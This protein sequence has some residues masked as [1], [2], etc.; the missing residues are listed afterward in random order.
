MARAQTASFAPLRADGNG[1]TALQRRVSLELERA[2]VA[3]A[4]RTVMRAADLDLVF[5]TDLPGLEQRISIDVK[6]VTAAAALLRVLENTRLRWLVS[7]AGQAVLVTADDP[8]AAAGGGVR[9]V[10]REAGGTGIAHVDI[11]AGGRTALTDAGG[12]FQLR[13]LSAGQHEL[14]A[15]RLGYRDTVLHVRVADGTDADITID[16]TSAP[17]PLA[18]VVVTPGYFGML[19][20]SVS[21]KQSLSREDIETRPQLGDD[22][23]RAV[24]RLPG[25]SAHDL[26]AAFHV[27]GGAQREVLVRLDGLELVEPFHLK[28]FEGGVSIIDVGSIGGVDLITGGFSAEY[29]NRLTGV[30]DMRTQA[31]LPG[32]GRTSLG[33]S[34]TNLRAAS[35]GAFAGDRGR[36]LFAAR[37]GYLDLALE[38]GNGNTALSPAYYDVLGK[39]EYEIAPRTLLSVHVLHAGDRM[40]YDDADPSEAT[41]ESKYGSSYAWLNLEARPHDRVSVLSVAVVG[42]LDWERLGVRVRDPRRFGG[43]RVEDRRSY[44]FVG[45]RQ[46]WSIEMS[47]RVLLKAGFD[48]RRGSAEYDYFSWTED[49]HAENGSVVATFDTTLAK[50]SPEGTSLGAYVS[51]RMRLGP[52]L[53]V[54]VGGEWSRHSHTGDSNVNPRANF[55]LTLAGNTLRGAWGRYSQAQGLH[56]LQAQDGVTAFAPAERAEQRVLSIERPL[57]NGLDVRVEAYERRSDRLRPRFL[58]VDNV[59]DMLP[60]V[61]RSRRRI[62]AERGRARG[63]EFIGRRSGSRFD[64]TASYALAS[65]QERVAGEWRPAQR[66]QR[67]ALAFDLAWTPDPRWRLAG[68]WQYHSGWAR[69]PEILHTDSLNNGSYWFSWDYGDYNTARLPAYHRMDLRV[70]RLFETRRGRVSVFIDIWNVYNRQ[71][72]RTLFTNV[73]GVRD[74]QPVTSQVADAMI[75]R[76]P[77]FGVFWEF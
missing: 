2:T 58:N 52:P 40:S 54:E 10:V 61:T 53:V 69:T 63:I 73:M 42:G 43:L 24:H 3:E 65:V 14:R 70:S 74:G 17:T 72:V 12:H 29:G 31:V 62:D 57:G 13:N 67:H 16:M 36:W 51:Q 26:S 1:V 39:V 20:Q 68:A 77:S 21:T 38:L 32:R 49:W 23:F 50:A 5:R 19:E 9:G 60:E 55:A 71:N 41:L 25:V 30:F 15:R 11:E 66:D 6:D 75:P 34:L 4:I 76:L 22:I 33:I 37:R 48:V 64:W 8:R 35:Q 45:A 28:D 7:A 18:A 56:E 27:R 47:D 59:D 44:G 46:D